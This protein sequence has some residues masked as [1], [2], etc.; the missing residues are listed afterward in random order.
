MHPAGNTPRTPVAVPAGIA[1][2]FQE[3]VRNVVAA[4]DE[5][6]RLAALA[7]CAIMHTPRESAFDNIVFTA[8][9]LFRAPVAILSLVDDKVAWAKAY[10]GPVPIE[11]PR[12]ETL[13][14]QVVEAGQLLVIEDTTVDARFAALAPSLDGLQLRFFA[15]APLFGPGRQPVGALAVFD[16]HPRNVPERQQ[17]HLVQLAHEAGE[18]L[19]LRV[20]GLDLTAT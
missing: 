1:R 20:P 3:F 5:S 6:A 16:R 14:A 7:S 10:V 15:G 11:R 9:Q 12:D 2:V 18:L 19:R 17:V 8:A 4:K 13:C